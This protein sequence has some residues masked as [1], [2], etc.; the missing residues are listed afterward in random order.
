MTQFATEI[1]KCLRDDRVL[2]KGSF[3]LDLD[4]LENNAFPDDDESQSSD[5][6]DD[7][8]DTSSSEEESSSDEENEEK[9][10]P[11]SESC[12]QGRNPVIKEASNLLDDQIGCRDG[13]DEEVCSN[14]QDLA[15]AEPNVLPAMHTDHNGQK[16]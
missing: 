2:E 12:P 15:N 1:R 4:I 6:D 3:A 10:N 5:D 8:D 7:D 16:K 14:D 13:L 11:D 9:T